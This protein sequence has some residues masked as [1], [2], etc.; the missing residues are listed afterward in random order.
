MNEKETNDRTFGTNEEQSKASDLVLIFRGEVPSKYT[1]HFSSATIG[2]S[3]R[4][5]H[6]YYVRSDSK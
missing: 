1:S 5:R 3:G 4:S 2:L 6:V